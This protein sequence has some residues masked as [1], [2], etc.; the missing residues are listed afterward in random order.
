MNMSARANAGHARAAVELGGV[1]GI[2]KARFVTVVV[3]VAMT[4]I[5]LVSMIVAVLFVAVGLVTMGV[6]VVVVFMIMLSV[7]M[8]VFALMLVFMIICIIAIWREY[9]G[10]IYIHLFFENKT[11]LIFC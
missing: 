7:I 9:I 8:R 11:E 3:P 5:V 1:L 4:V 6:P 2:V 10:D